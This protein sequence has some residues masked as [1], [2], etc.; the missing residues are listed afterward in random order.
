M[1]AVLLVGVALAAIASSGAWAMQRRDGRRESAAREAGTEPA[2]PRKVAAAKPPSP[3]GRRQTEQR[4]DRLLTASLK[5]LLR[6]DSGSLA[7]GAVDL[8]DGVRVLSNAGQHF[9]TASIVK[10]D[11]LA[12]LLLQ[13]QAAGTSLSA[14]QRE[15]A[16]EMIEHSDN[17]AATDLWR[18]IGGTSGLAAA[19][20]R[21]GLRETVPGTAGYWGLTSTTVT[22]QL[23]LLADLVARRS[24]LSSSSRA[25]ELSLMRSV[26][27]DQDWGVSAAATAG[28]S[29]AVKNGWLPDPEL[30]VINSIGLVDHAGRR[31]LLVVLSKNQPSEVYGISRCERAAL[32]AARAVTQTASNA[33]Q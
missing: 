19:N 9:H 11:I 3:G 13:H 7:V 33:S 25:F 23:R 21:L 4:A 14:E 16:V 17:D 27:P 1:T 30:W 5:G 31:L 26:E 24:P 29:A 12:A 10:A 8:S 18:E 22:D 20:A 2:G 15:L 28:T 6:S 32:A